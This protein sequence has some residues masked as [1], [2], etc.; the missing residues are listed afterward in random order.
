MK[1]IFIVGLPGSGKSY[2]GKKLAEQTNAIGYFD[3]LSV[4]DKSVF[5][6][7]KK[8]LFQKQGTI[9]VNDVY[10]C[11]PKH[12]ESALNLIKEVN[13]KIQWIYFENNL[14]KC[15]RN[16]EFRNDGRDVEGSLLRFSKSYV[17]PENVEPLLIWQ[18]D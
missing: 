2:L 11:E 17:I 14:E 9:I 8:L 4:A 3:D 1:I 10:L 15:R 16:V 12:R 18:P 7:F 6:R 5:E 13:P